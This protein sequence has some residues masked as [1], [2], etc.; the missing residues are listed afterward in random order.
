M[1]KKIQYYVQMSLQ[2]VREEIQ[3]LDFFIENI[4]NTLKEEVQYLV[5]MSLQ[6]IYTIQLEKKY[7]IKY[8]NI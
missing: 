6:K 4:Y 2:T 7:N 1:Y 5:Q 8:F 3:K